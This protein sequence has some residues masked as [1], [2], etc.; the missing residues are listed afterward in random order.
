MNYSILLIS[1]MFYS[2]ILCNYLSIDYKKATH[3][4]YIDVKLNQS[5]SDMHALVNT[6]LPFSLFEPSLKLNKKSAVKKSIDISLSYNKTYDQYTTSLSYHSLEI[7]KYSFL[8]GDISSFK[9][10]NGF[11]FGRLF[12]D[13]SFSI[14][15]QLYNS[16]QIKYKTFAFKSNLE[17]INGKI[18]FGGIPDDKDYQFKGFCKVDNTFPNWGCNLT[19]MKYNDTS[20]SFN[21]YALF[22]SGFYGLLYSDNV[23]DFIANVVFKNEIENKICYI[24]EISER[25]KG[26]NCQNSFKNELT[27]EDTFE[28][29]FGNI[30]IKYPKKLLF[31]ESSS[32][33]FTNPYDYY[34]KYD[35]I[36]GVD[37]INS[38]NYT[39]FDY[40][41]NQIGFYSDKIAINISSNNN[42]ENTIK[43]I[44]IL[45]LSLNA[46][47]LILLLF[48]KQSYM[49]T[50]M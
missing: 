39:I 17:H 41:N 31:D 12:E 3:R 32:I 8:Y 24:E 45:S 21:N 36:L 7:D 34:L 46:V 28:F 23:F 1:T 44:L 38:F 48:I 29:V 16:H 18:Y 14:V 15:H 22:H 4:I 6:F 40:D 13:E 27:Y 49:N 50:L 35:I 26:F 10:D 2:H 5:E 11:S 25:R 9:P 19:Q 47:D 37:F 33:F 30:Q 43:S 42:R 20:V